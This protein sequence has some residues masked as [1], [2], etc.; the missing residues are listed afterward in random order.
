MPVRAPLLS[1]RAGPGHGAALTGS[2]LAHVALLGLLLWFGAPR[3]AHDPG[4]AAERLEM[5]FEAAPVP[6]PAPVSAAPFDPAPAEAPV[7]DPAPLE[8][9]VPDPALLE[10]PIPGLPPEAAAPTPAEPP[11]AASQAEPSPP[12]AADPP[13]PIVAPIVPPPPAPAPAVRRPPP[14]RPA[15]RPKTT[16]DRAAPASE[17]TPP[18]MPGRPSSPAAAAPA[19]VAPPAIAAPPAAAAAISPSWRRAVVT[20]L[21]EH[22]RYPDAARRRGEA[23]AVGVSFAVAHDG[24]V[25]DAMVTSSSGSTILDDAVLALLSGGHVPPFPPDMPQAE[26]RIAVRVV[27]TLE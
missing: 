14:M 23:G 15:T 22:K 5:V 19:P 6:A 11:Q 17:P 12:V 8:A 4:P 7:P 20:W 21:Q 16:T 18:P 9:P 25:G 3:P 26:A 13:P 27:Y 2:S 24:R 1:R 10:A